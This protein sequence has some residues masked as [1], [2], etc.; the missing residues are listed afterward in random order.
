MLRWIAENRIAAFERDYDYDMTYIRELLATDLGAF[1]AFTRFQSLANY[2]KDLPRD[3][4]YGA[5]ITG[6]MIGD[7]GP[8]TQLVVTMALREGVPPD[9]I[10]AVLRR[11]D[12]ALPEDVRLTVQF[13][14]ASLAHDPDADPLREQIVKRWGQRALVTLAYTLVTT[15]V[16]PTLKYALGHGKACQRVVVAGAPIAV[17]AGAA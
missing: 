9:L 15:Q 16:Y 7:C 2:R 3:P 8:C 10:S 1:Y 12:D 5:K 13:A 17:A 14:R 4:L 11:Q 6:T